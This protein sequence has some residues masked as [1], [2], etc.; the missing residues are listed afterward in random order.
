LVAVLL[1]KFFPFFF[2]AH[3]N[4][5]SSKNIIH[6]QKHSTLARHKIKGEWMWWAPEPQTANHHHPNLFLLI[7]SYLSIDIDNEN[8]IIINNN[9]NN[10]NTTTM[11]R[12]IDGLFFFAKMAVMVL[13]MWRAT[14][15]HGFT[16]TP[17][18]ITTTTTTT[19]TARSMGIFDGIS[20]AFSNTEYGP[21]AE[22]V[23]A[24]A[25]HILVPSQG[26][27]NMVIKMITTGEESFENCARDYS[28]CPSSKQGGSLG[29]FTP[30]TMVPAFDKVIF[31][32]DT[33]IGQVLGPV[34]TEFG[35]H[36][37]MVDK[38][39]GGGDWY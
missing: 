8:N 31:N 28:T 36:V 26:E 4:H 11:L 39:T 22:A 27:A 7:T 38:R 15:T 21:P 5:T 17:I 25:R 30:G 29:S 32:P 35:F 20:K 24:T 18:T 9:N 23:K 33:A 14:C 6:Q 3:I 34:M 16:A 1:T 37:I 10:N 19:T 2:L 13:I 12:S